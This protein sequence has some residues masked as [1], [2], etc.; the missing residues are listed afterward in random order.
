MGFRKRSQAYVSWRPRLFHGICN[1][2]DRTSRQVG[3]RRLWREGW[4]NAVHRGPAG[5][6]FAAHESPRPVTAVQWIDRQPRR[7]S[8]GRLER[9]GC[10]GES[11]RKV[12]NERV[13]RRIEGHGSNIAGVRRNTLC[14]Q[15]LQIIVLV[16][17]NCTKR[18][19]VGPLRTGDEAR[20][21]PDPLARAA[22]LYG[23]RASA[24]KLEAQ[25]SGSVTDRRRGERKTRSTCSRC[26]L[27]WGTR[28]RI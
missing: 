20:E 15:C 16:P 11:R 24:Y 23:G 13:V 26:V 3:Q 10:V 28:Q 17:F 22:C 2:L 6:L 19:R 8:R 27:V 25:A 5:A 9:T 21:T 1:R 18:K 7:E 4:P 14:C 12:A